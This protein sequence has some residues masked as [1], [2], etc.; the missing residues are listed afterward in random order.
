[1]A[2]GRQAPVAL[3]RRQAAVFAFGRV[4][5]HGYREPTLLGR[6]SMDML[7]VYKDAVCILPAAVKVVH[8]C[9]AG[10]A[11]GDGLP[12]SGSSSSGG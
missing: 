5:V 1:M 6:N 7:L 3:E 2:T 10:Q 9:P 4:Q 8:G 11:A 12:G